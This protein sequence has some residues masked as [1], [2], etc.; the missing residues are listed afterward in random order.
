MIPPRRYGT[1]GFAVLAALLA[2]AM[3][4]RRA[5][6]LDVIRRYSPRN[7]E[8]PRRSATLHIILHTTEGEEAGSFR[9]VH[10]RGETHYF[11]GLDGRVY[12]IIH[13]DRVALHAGRSMWNGRSNLDTRSVGIEVVGCHNGDITRAQYQAT[14]E[15]IGM[16]QKRYGIPDADVLTHSMVAYGAPNRWHSRS[17]RGRKRCGMLFARRSVRHRLG[18]SAQPAFD[19]DVR[20]GRLVN[21][22][23]YL[24][25]VLYAGAGEQAAAAAV[26]AAAAGDVIAAGRSAWDIARDAYNG[27][28]TTYVFPDGRR[29]RGNEIKDWKAIPAGTRVAVGD[30]E[31]ENAPEGLR[32]I[33]RDGATA[34]DVAGGEYASRTT[35]YFL[36]DGRVR[37]GDQ[38]AEAE[39][40]ALAEGVGILV[41][42]TSAG[43]VSAQRSAFDICGKRWSFPS[44]YYRFPDG[45]LVP[46]DRVNENGIPKAT[47]VF[48]RN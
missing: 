6:A 45:R 40:K 42:Y 28:G 11:V 32:R 7:G 13:P 1:A 24:A 17:H 8:R 27:S 44:T 22:D 18:L 9:K 12:G 43:Y 2:A 47:M 16:L 38:M 39:F 48:Y 19:P 41:G 46:G 15:L 26:S 30:Q 5:V 36:P 29:M 21:A 25:Q 20:A 14:A 37:R 35:I 33:G 23:P 34:A 4:C 10:E 3:P 31:S